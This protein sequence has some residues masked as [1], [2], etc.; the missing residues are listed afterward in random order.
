MK[1]ERVYLGAQ[2]NFIGLHGIEDETS[3]IP[4]TDDISV[5]V[6]QRSG[7]WFKIRELAVATVNN[8]TTVNQ[9]YASGNAKKKGN[10]LIKI[11]T[12]LTYIQ[13]DW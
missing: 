2:S 1:D 13:G 11:L 9:G 12:Y 8:C 10:R 6:K 5:V 3:E 4:L 7:L